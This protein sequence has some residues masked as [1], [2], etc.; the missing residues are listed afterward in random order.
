MYDWV[1]LLHSRSWHNIVNQLYFNKKFFKFLNIKKKTGQMSETMLFRR[2]PSGSGSRGPWEERTSDGSSL[3]CFSL[4]VG[5]P[6]RSCTFGWKAY[7]VSFEF[8]LNLWQK[9]HWPQTYGLFLCALFCFIDLSVCLDVNATSPWM[10]WLYSKS[11]GQA[12]SAR[13]GGV[14][15]K[16]DK[17]INT[18]CWN[19]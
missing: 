11:P 7:P 18:S 9:M 12:G 3:D 5:K 15:I 1:T 13:Q 4:L 16:R 19:N 8:P 6:S 14:C 10:L 2:R 17:Q